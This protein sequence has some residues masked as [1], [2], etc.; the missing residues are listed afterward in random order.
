MVGTKAVPLL[1]VGMLATGISNSLFMKWQDMQCVGNCDDPD[2][3]KHIEFNQP[4]WQVSSRRGI[5]GNSIDLDL[6]LML[7][8]LSCLL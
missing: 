6:S 2:P 1:I 8:Y 4:V 5:Q 7:H 3:S